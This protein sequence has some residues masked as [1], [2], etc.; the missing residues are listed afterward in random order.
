MS[1]ST[2][3]PTSRRG[4]RSTA[5]AASLDSPGQEAAPLA[6]DSL[7]DTPST[8]GSG[9]TTDWGTTGG[10]SG[11]VTE[12]A[13][14]AAGNVASTVKEE[15][16]GVAQDAK[17]QARDLYHQVRR[18]VSDQGSNQQQRAVTGLNTLAG[19]F[20]Q[21]A[22]GAQ[23]GGMATDLAQQAATRMR[24]LASWLESREPGD[25]LE[26]LRSFARRRPGAFIAAAAGLGVLA[27]RLTRGLV[28]DESGSSTTSGYSPTSR[29]GATGETG[30]Y[31]GSAEPL[32]TAAGLSGTES[33][34]GS[35]AGS[36]AGDELG[37]DD[38]VSTPASTPTSTPTSSDYRD[39]SRDD[40]GDLP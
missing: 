19:Q 27:G 4:G 40:R 18:E 38:R 3:D 23:D 28:D 39:G 8:A 33:Y 30:S 36:A 26:E 24:S 9:T 12:D 16:R 21:M 7:G 22:G 17:Q 2:Y 11:G 10:T 25:V 15:T 32:G 31:R 34:Y 1:D 6:A 20:E 13:K 14:Q 5:E 37:L 35:A 29:V